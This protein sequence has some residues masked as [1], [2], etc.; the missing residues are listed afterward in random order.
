LHLRESLLRQ[1]EALREKLAGPGASLIERL[2]AER[3]ATCWLQLSY[4][5]ALEA[6]SLAAD[7][8]PRLAGFRAKRQE[9]GHRMYLTSLAA[10]VTL[11]KLLPGTAGKTLPSPKGNDPAQ[12]TQSGHHHNGR[13][14]D[15]AG[16]S[17]AG[18]NRLT[19]VFDEVLG[20]DK[21]IRSRECCSATVGD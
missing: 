17:T 11:R 14:A 8:K 16:V 18:H 12:A 5:V 2:L 10:L 7:N 15:L 4:C 3:V 19:G 20:G 9:Q 1:A 6:Q 13:K 21:G